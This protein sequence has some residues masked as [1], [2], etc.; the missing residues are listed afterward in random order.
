MADDQ[1]EILIGVCARPYPYNI[2]GF[3]Y[4]GEPLRPR[5]RPSE[6]KPPTTWERFRRRTLHGW[7]VV[8]SFMLDV[9]TPPTLTPPNL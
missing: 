3:N 2:P 1:G 7:Q 4:Y 6:I 8:Y 5:S 9:V